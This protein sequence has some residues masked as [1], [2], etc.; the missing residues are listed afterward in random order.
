MKH[1]KRIILFLLSFALLFS[2]CILP[3]GAG[4]EVKY[5]YAAEVLWKDGLFLGSGDSFD[6]DKPLIRAAG[7]AMIVRLSSG[8]GGGS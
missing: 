4:Y 6:L 8:Q 1:Q 5:G 2:T 3:A 7:A